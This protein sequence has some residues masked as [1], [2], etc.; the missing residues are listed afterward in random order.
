LSFSLIEVPVDDAE[1]SIFYS[2]SYL[3]EYLKLFG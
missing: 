2:I 3:M 1:I